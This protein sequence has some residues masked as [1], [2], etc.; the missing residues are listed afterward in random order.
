MSRIAVPL[1]AAIGAQLVPLGAVDAQLGLYT[2][3]R[4]DFVWNWGNTREDLRRGAADI[5]VSGNESIFR[6]D[7]TAQIRA[8]SSLSTTDVRA[9]EQELQARLDFIYAASEMMNQLEYSH[10]LDWATLDCKKYEAAPST[11]EQ[12]AERESEARDKMLREL[13]RRRERAQRD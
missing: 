11:P 12:R 4:N 3:P 2:L 6:C 1:I 9:I 10:N 13:E 7:L 8:S 5:E